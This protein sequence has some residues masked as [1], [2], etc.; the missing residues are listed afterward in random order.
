VASAYG[1]AGSVLVL[2]AWVY[3][4]SQILF[5]GAEFTK[6]HAEEHRSRVKPGRGVVPVS[7]QAKQRARGEKPARHDHREVSRKRA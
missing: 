2:F 7:E 3:Y 4:S 1:A 6:L 5:F